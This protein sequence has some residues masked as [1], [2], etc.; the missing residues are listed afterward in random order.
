[1]TWGHW[2][3]LAIAVISLII[4]VSLRWARRNSRGPGRPG[5]V[6]EWFDRSWFASLSSRVWLVALV[7]VLIYPKE[8]LMKDDFKQEISKKIRETNWASVRAGSGRSAR[9]GTTAARPAGRGAPRR[10]GR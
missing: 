1:M 6:I 7:A 9:P 10:L 4:W 5:R 8:I 2:V 3:S